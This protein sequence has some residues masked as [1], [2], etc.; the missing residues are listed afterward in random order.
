M[1]FFVDVLCCCSGVVGSV[2]DQSGSYIMNPDMKKIIL[3]RGIEL[4]LDLVFV[5]TKICYM[6]LI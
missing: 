5:V 3:Y 6:D 4:G 2:V 1:S